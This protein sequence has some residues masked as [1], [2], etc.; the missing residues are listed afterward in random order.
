[1][2]NGCPPGSQQYTIAAGDTLFGLAQRFGTTVAAITSAN[3][4]INPNDL[5][6][7]QLICI[8][9]GGGAP[10]PGPGPCP[11]TFY[12]IRSGDTLFRIA[13]ER[14]TTVDAIIRL[15]PSLNPNNLQ[16]GQIICLP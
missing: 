14:G 7:G 11:G 5:R 16:V 12:T 8:P 3:P 2:P 6:V 13:T 4:G 9:R 15:N 1:M 10:G